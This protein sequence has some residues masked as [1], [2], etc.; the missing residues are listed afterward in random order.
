MNRQDLKAV[1]PMGLSAFCLL[2]GYAFFRP[3]INSLFKEVY[4]AERLPLAM[5]FGV[6]GILLAVWIYAR[7][8]SWGGPRM[9]LAISCGA[10]AGLI[11]VH[12]LGLRYQFH[13][14]VF[15]RLPAQRGLYC[16][17]H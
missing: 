6:I 4:G 12:F 7:L 17:H 13:G 1:V 11:L 10:S 3:A 9:T 14:M 16:P 8:L 2:A 15:T 5:G